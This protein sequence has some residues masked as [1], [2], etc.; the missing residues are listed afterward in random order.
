[1]KYSSIESMIKDRSWKRPDSYAGPDH[2]D[3][4]QV[5][6]RHRDSDLLAQSNFEVAL[7]RLGGESATVEVVRDSHWA[8][9]WVETI[10]VSKKD[11]KALKEVKG[12]L[13]SLDD[14]GA[15]DEDDYFEREQ[16]ERERIFED[17]KEEFIAVAIKALVTKTDVPESILICLSTSKSF[18]ALVSEAFHEAV[19]YSG[20]ED[21]WVCETNFVRLFQNMYRSNYA[22]QDLNLM[23]NA[24]EQALGVK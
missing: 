17:N 20:I 2:D 9:G 12:I 3:T 13:N 24:I 19:S 23:N 10:F 6:G 16:E 11:R 21:A 15:L 1:M 22:N 18:E 7:D 14:Y 4:I 8:F 5:I